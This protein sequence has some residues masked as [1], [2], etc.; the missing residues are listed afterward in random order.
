MKRPR[1]NKS[2]LE[3]VSF[4]RFYGRTPATAV[5]MLMHALEL[6]RDKMNFFKLRF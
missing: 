3:C 1:I 6:E 5:Y 2:E 4:V